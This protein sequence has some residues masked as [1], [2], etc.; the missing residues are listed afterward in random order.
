VNKHL[1]ENGLVLRDRSMVDTTII[2]STSSTKNSTGKRDQ[3]VGPPA[4]HQ[5]RKGNECHFGMKMHIGVDDTLGL[6]TALIR[7]VPMFMKSCLSANCCTA[8]SGESLVMPAIS[9]YKSEAST[10]TIKTWRGS[11][12]STLVQEKPWL[13]TCWLK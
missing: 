9:A 8:K 1:E 13:L 2:S 4:M 3:T 6:S 12:P 7:S 5:T 11:S 10:S